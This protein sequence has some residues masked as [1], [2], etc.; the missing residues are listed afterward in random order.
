VRNPAGTGYFAGYNAQN[1]P[2]GSYLLDGTILSAYNNRYTNLA[3]LEARGIDIG[4]NYR[5]DVGPGSLRASFAGQYLLNQ[6]T[7]AQVGTAGLDNAGQYR[8]PRFRGTLNTRFI[9]AS[10][11]DPTKSDEYYQFQKI[12]AY[13]YNDVAINYRATEQVTFTL[14][15]RNVSNVDVPLQLYNNTISP[16]LANGSTSGSGGAAYYDAIGRYFYAK[17]DVNF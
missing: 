15:V 3:S 16:H 9:G 13:V 7:V 14:G 1:D 10:K 8:T 17:V 6:I 5:T 12:P 4:V 11:F 2:T